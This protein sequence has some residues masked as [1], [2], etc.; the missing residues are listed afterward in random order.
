MTVVVPIGHVSSRQLAALDPAAG[1][2]G[3]GFRDI[4]SAFH[5]ERSRGTIMLKRFG[6]DLYLHPYL[7]YSLAPGYRSAALNTDGEGFRL[8]ASPFGTIGSAAWAS[9]GGGLMLGNS[10]AVGI[11]ASSDRATVASHLAF[12]TQSRWLNLGII[13]ANSLQELIAAVPFL[14]AA[15]T[16][17]V[18]SGLG[19]YLAM[20]RTR[21]GGGAFG[22]I[23]YEGTW[24]KLADIPI[25]ELAGLVAGETLADGG[26][27]RS[28]RPVPPEPDLT[29]A[30]ARVETAA[31]MQ[32][33]DLR[34]LARTASPGTQILFCL[35]PMATP[36]TRAITAEEQ[37]H[38][39]FHAPIFGLLHDVIE[40]CFDLYAKRL[41][42][43]CSDLGVP[44]LRMSADE[45][46][47]RSFATNFILTDEGNRQAA[48]MIHHALGGASASVPHRAAP[49]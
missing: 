17:V 13:G 39:D 26:N 38:Y 47:G 9:G 32:L 20:L 42:E 35:Q 28:R 12:L 45:F 22:P 24:A 1:I 4:G 41:A 27:D 44:F 29:D 18:L 8:S 7:G 46:A 14:D 15:S 2:S 21:I 16:V 43:G 30:A 5:E 36:R 33:R 3:M 34:F 25:F 19:N 23:V 31:R 49:T 6:L 10:V 37:E 48:Q 11:G 40:N